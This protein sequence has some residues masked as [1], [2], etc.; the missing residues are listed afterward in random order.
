[1]TRAS[2]DSERSDDSELPQMRV[3]IATPERPAFLRV[4][5]PSHDELKALLV[6]YVAY[7]SPC[8]ASHATA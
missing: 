7:S 4:A 1:M 8:C 3:T 5:D 6:K 2:V